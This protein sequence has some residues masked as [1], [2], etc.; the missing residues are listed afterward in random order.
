MEKSPRLDC[1]RGAKKSR[2]KNKK[3]TGKEEVPIGLEWFFKLVATGLEPAYRALLPQ[4]LTGGTTDC[5]T[6]P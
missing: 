4:C 5:A 1:G 6:L 3:P 2:K